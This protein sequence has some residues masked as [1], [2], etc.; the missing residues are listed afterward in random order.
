M[1]WQEFSASW[2]LIPENPLGIIHFLGGAFVA[3][4][5]HIT[6]RC[7]LEN[8]A[9]QGYIIIATS[10]LN[11]LD[12]KAIAVNVQNQLEN[13]LYR[14]EYK[15]GIEISYLPIYGLG[16]SMGCKLHLLIGSLFDI[17]RAGNIF[18]SFN[19]YPFKKAIPF[20]E[21]IIPSL[22]DNLKNYLQIDNNLDFEF[23]PSPEET[24]II[25][26]ENYQIRRNLLV[27][28]KDDT[29]DQTLT[30]KP[31]LIDLFPHMTS[32]LKLSGNH[33][34]PLGQDIDW[35][36]GDFLIPIDDTIRQ[37]FKENFSRDLY[38][39]HREISR[40]LNPVNN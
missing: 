33:L 26:K 28:F 34:T 17:E 37:W 3:T 29:I 35:K 32:T 8:L 19:N 4:A 18:I 30:L 25:V 16:H 36:L 20:V 31:I 9:K 7:F 13:I 6:Y 15:E 24:K 11:T 38:N 1:E 5:P 23:T 39:L 10:F 27:Q 21:N 12:H 22:K 2:V 14:L 40:W